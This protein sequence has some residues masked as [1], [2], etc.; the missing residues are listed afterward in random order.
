M[1]ADPVATAPIAMREHAS[2]S[3][4]NSMDCHWE[5]ATYRALAP[6]VIG[7]GPEARAIPYG[8]TYLF[9]L[10]TRSRPVFKL[11]ATPVQS[12]LWD[13]LDQPRSVAELVT[14]M[15]QLVPT[16]RPIDALWVIADLRRRRL[17]QAVAEVAV[18]GVDRPRVPQ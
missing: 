14:A 15:R 2:L 18:A 7:R 4:G 9:V 10:R 8:N 13:L 1:G 3:R 12:H 17:L 16:M 5:Q 11:H 6:S